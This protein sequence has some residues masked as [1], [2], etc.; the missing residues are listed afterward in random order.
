MAS[1]G[2]FEPK[3]RKRA[4]VSSLHVQTH[5][6]AG[7]SNHTGQGGKGL[8]SGPGLPGAHDLATSLM[9]ASPQPPNA[10]WV[11]RCLPPCPCLLAPLLRHSLGSRQ[12]SKG[13]QEREVDKEEVGGGPR[14]AR[15]GLRTTG[16]PCCSGGRFSAECTEGVQ[17]NAR[18]PPL[19]KLVELK[20]GTQLFYHPHP[21]SAPEKMKGWI[22]RG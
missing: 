16:S 3:A 8:R 13:C 10:P 7:R 6:L 14:R 15:A 21:Q 5:Y 2:T 20:T 11:S 12:G 22:W 1:T 17:V 4:P 9:P 18:S 19:L